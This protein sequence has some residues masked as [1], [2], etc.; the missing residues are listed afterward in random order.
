MM[1]AHAEPFRQKSEPNG[2]TT[3]VPGRDR[4]V[5]ASGRESI[6]LPCASPAPFDAEERTLF[7]DSLSFYRVMLHDGSNE[8]EYRAS[9]ESL[10]I[11]LLES[12][13]SGDM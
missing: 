13:S 6:G 12:F 9:Q 7:R 4:V 2:V 8:V 3:E 11:V 5:A 10:L 1:D